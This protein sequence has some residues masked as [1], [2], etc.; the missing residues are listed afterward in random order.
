MNAIRRHKNGTTNQVML[1]LGET[2]LSNSMSINEPQIYYTDAGTK[3]NGSFG[4]QHTIIVVTDDE[5]SGRCLCEEVVGDKTNNE[6]ELLALIWAME[7]LKKKKMVLLSD[8][9]L[10]VNWITGKY[11]MSKIERLQPLIMKGRSLYMDT[12]AEIRWIP[13]LQNKAGWF[14]EEKYGL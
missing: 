2:I 1:P 10:A 4:N 5:G 11:K 6:G 12:K 14:I 8:S 9:S 3:N 7:H 13:R